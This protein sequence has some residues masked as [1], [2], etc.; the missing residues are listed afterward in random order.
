MAEREVAVVVGVGPGLGA[1]VAR[2]FAKSGMAVA[3][4]SRRVD[5]LKSVVAQ[6]QGLGG[7][8]I[9]VACDATKESD[10]EAL[11]TRVRA[12][13]G[14]PDVVVFNASG[15]ARG[16]VLDIKIDEFERSWRNACLG[17]LLVG[18]AAARIMVGRG[19][20]TIVFTGATAS[21]RG[22]AEFAGFA[23][24]KFGLRAVAQAMARELGPKGVHVAHV[25]V[26]GQ[27]RSEQYA[28]LARSRPADGL[29][30]PDAIAANYLFLHRQHRSAWSHEL[31]LRPWVEKF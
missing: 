5:K 12:E 9:A 7:K 8:A 20:G 25:I 11:F 19:R 15:F 4:A 10:V 6:V 2:T 14:L 28:E 31:D 24:G 3:T 1:A 30:A 22:S 18:R 17:G 16:S 26:D 29:L 27:I 13:F 23:V 21:L